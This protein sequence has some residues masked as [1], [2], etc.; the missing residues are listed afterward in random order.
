MEIAQLIA[1]FAA[2]ANFEMST[3]LIAVLALEFIAYVG[4]GVLLLVTKK[5]WAAA[6]TCG[7]AF[8]LMVYNL[9]VNQIFTSY[10]VVAFSVWAI[11]SLILLEKKF[12]N[13]ENR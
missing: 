6:I 4:G 7:V 3:F 1:M 11:V 13:E 5:W 8:L 10:L 12:K 2:N 9:V